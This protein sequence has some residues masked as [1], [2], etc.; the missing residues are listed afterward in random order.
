MRS[1]LAEALGTALLVFVAVGTATL[2]FGFEVA[3]ASASAGVVATALA[4][5]LVL[6]AMVYAVGPISGCH[7]NPAVTIGFLAARRISLADAAGY[8]AAQLVGAIAGA[9]VL[10]G[11]VHAASS[12]E[13]SMGL[14]ADG[15]GTHSMVGLNAGGTFLVEV[16]LTF[17]FV[18]VVLATTRRAENATVAGLVIGLALALVH[19]VGIP[20]DGT[21]VNPARSIAPA[22]FVGGDALSQLWVFVVAPLVGGALAALVYAFLYPAGE[23]EAAVEPAPELQPR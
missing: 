16:V 6:T 9:A 22:L 12:Y 11:A 20:L 14:G 17:V 18:L 19:L 3:G 8:W 2:S 4:F 15:Y 21:S 7:I 10:Y 5:G 13:G 1:L 23:E